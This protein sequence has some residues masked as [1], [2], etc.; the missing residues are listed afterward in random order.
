MSRQADVYV[1]KEFCGVLTEHE[2]NASYTF[3]YRPDYSSYPVFFGMPV[4]E[5]EYKDI[6]FPPRFESLL[7]EGILLEQLLSTAKLDKS[8]KFGQLLIVG[9]DLPGYLTIYPSG[10]NPKHL[11]EIK[12]GTIKRRFENL[13][14]IP[15]SYN[16]DDLV[17]YHSKNRV[18]MSIS[19]VQP[20]VQATYS[21]SKSEFM[22]VNKGGSFILKPQN[23]AFKNLPENEF[24][25]MSLAKS[26]GIETPNF[27]IFKNQSGEYI[28]Y[29]QRFDRFGSKNSESIR[30]ED[31]TQILNSPTAWKY[32]GTVEMVISGID[33]LTNNPRVQLEDF[34]HR[35]LFNWVIGNDD[36]HLKNWSLIEERIN[37]NAFVRLSPAYDYV[38]SKI[39][40][41][42]SE[43]ESALS[44]AEEKKGFTKEILLEYLG[45]EYCELNQRQI[46]SILNSFESV[47]WSKSIE[48]S[49]LP[50]TLKSNYKDIVFNN[51][52]ILG[53]S[54]T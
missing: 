51:L 28:Y 36:M 45:R 46:K 1:G 47:D 27:G 23:P 38:N 25:S 54:Q 22:I 32:H 11:K 8:D 14:P 19:G 17:K 42:D 24:L 37:E 48:D 53:I 40:I 2:V 4:V 30:M 50:N 16:S 10:S 43:E 44:L 5:T 7:P 52:N 41:E 26:V 13:N 3:Q 34:F 33:E 20:K 49:P 31:F 39:V 15:I 18:H 21:R 12:D 29:I 9:E 6:N 35:F